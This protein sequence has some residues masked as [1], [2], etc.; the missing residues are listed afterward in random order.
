MKNDHSKMWVFLLFIIT[1]FVLLT[2]FVN[3]A[4]L[5][6]LSKKAGWGRGKMA[7]SERGYY[8]YRLRAIGNKWRKTFVDHGYNR[9]G[10]ARDGYDSFLVI[11]TL[12]GAM[13]VET[14]GN[15]A[16][17]DYCDLPANMKWKIYRTSNGKNEDIPKVLKLKMRGIWTGQE[18]PEMYCFHGIDRSKDS[19]S[20]YVTSGDIFTDYGGSGYNIQNWEKPAKPINTENYFKPLIVSD[21]EWLAYQ[22]KYGT[23]AIPQNSDKDNQN[24]EAKLYDSL[25]KICQY[26]ELETARHGHKL[27][28]LHRYEIASNYNAIKGEMSLDDDG[29]SIIPIRRRRIHEDNLFRA[30]LL[31]DDLWY[32]QTFPEENGRIRPN[33]EVLNFAFAMQDGKILS[34]A[35]FKKL[36]DDIK[37]RFAV[38]APINPDWIQK[39]A[40]GAEVEL[41]GICYR[42]SF[43]GKWWGPDGKYLEYEPYYGSESGGM[44]NKDEICYYDIAFRIYWPSGTNRTSNSVTSI[45]SITPGTTGSTG[46]SSGGNHP[47]SR[48]YLLNVQANKDLNELDVQVDIE[49]QKQK[50]Q[51]VVFRAIPLAPGNSKNFK[52]TVDSN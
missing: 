47:A 49:L 2:P 5:D 14:R 48:I 44:S 30:Q 16:R 10:L 36:S 51:S 21:A 43:G 27:D 32:V 20:I 31:D 19:F 46:M 18:Y 52:I 3:G 12:N 35:D 13:W 33:D 38:E 34:K 42:P 24:Q 50:P 23:A 41:L 15:I 11:D 1:V 6:T 17:Q 9:D 4:K 37:D 45:K 22:N 28:Y 40:N 29:G 8:E 26:I 7:A 39:M 25:K